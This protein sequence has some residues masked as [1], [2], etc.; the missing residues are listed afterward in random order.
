MLVREG[1][2]IPHIKLAQ[3]TKFMDWSKLTLQVFGEGKAEGYIC[4]PEDNKLHSITVENGSLV[5]NP[6]E[7]KSELVIQ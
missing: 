2:V 7:G 6:V 4:L 1:A 5:S 3:S